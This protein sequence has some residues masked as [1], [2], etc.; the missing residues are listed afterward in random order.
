MSSAHPSLRFFAVRERRSEMRA[1]RR[2]RSLSGL[3]V[4]A[5][6][7]LAAAVASA[8]TVSRLDQ[9]I[10]RG[11]VRV[12]TTGDYKPFSYLNPASNEYE[13][14]DIDAARLLAESLGVQV[15]FV[16][17][18]WPT[19]LKGLQEDQY[20]IAMCGITRTMPRQRVAAL[21]H[22]YINVGKSPLIRA[23]DRQRFK[24]LADID[25]PG[26]KI[27]VNP[28]GT[29]QRF[30]DANIKKA[31][32]VVIEKNLSIPEKIVAGDVDVMITDN[33]EAMLVAKQD[34][35]LYAVD[36]E[37]TYTR[38]DFGYLLPRD[39]QA[40]VNYVNLWVDLMRLKGEFARL[41]QKWIR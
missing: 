18:T 3:L 23:A 25:Q 37:N 38:D 41:Q 5:L 27:G 15:R 20:D 7:L 30:V 28:G 16:N 19:L 26:V 21:T 31:T 34:P 17:T 12:G 1:M 24:S 10:Q 4:V 39:D 32:V 2:L 14:H 13:G 29:N 40:W 35:R 22:P 36:P 9:I 8:Q 11:Y 33:V 6:I